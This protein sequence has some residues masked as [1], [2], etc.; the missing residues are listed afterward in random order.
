MVEGKLQIFVSVYHESMYDF[1]RVL[2]HSYMIAV[3]IQ[4][5]SYR[6]HIIY[7]CLS[8]A[9]SFQNP[10]SNCKRNQFWSASI[11]FKRNRWIHCRGKGIL[12]KQS[13]VLRKAVKQTR[14][15]WRER[16]YRERLIMIEYKSVLSLNLSSN[17]VFRN[18]LFLS[19]RYDKE[20]IDF[21]KY[22]S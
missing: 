9:I 8:T 6:C 5:K 14:S 20:S 3:E 19:L 12:L 7:K 1:Y 2:E 18:V 11:Y 4:Y 15:K 16:P 21:S 10:N 13:R 17:Q 22:S